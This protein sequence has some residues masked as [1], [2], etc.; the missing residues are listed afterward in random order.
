MVIRVFIFEDH[1]MCREALV[2][3]LG[4]EADLVVVGTTADVSEGL[5][6]LITARPDVVL[7]DMRFH[8]ETRGIEATARIKAMLPHTQVI[9][10]T[11]FP[12]GYRSGSSGEGGRMRVSAQEGGAEFGHDCG[13]HPRRSSGRCL[14]DAHGRD[15]GAPGDQAPVAQQRLWTDGTRGPDSETDRRRAGKP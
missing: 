2:A 5:A 10:F 11:E 12:G 15:P 8:G 3:V 4:Q 13:R 6:A 14:F 7:M 9:I 1:W